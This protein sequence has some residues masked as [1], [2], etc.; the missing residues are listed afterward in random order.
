MQDNPN[1]TLPSTQDLLKKVYKKVRFPKPKGLRVF[2]K[3]ARKAA[4]RMK[5]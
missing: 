4:K 1:N 5:E 2:K 3:A